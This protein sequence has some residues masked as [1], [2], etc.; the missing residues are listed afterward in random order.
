[1][2]AQLADESRLGLGDGVLIVAVTSLLAFSLLLQVSPQP[3]GLLGAALDT[4]QSLG[5]FALEALQALGAL[6]LVGLQALAELALESLKNL[7]G[8][9]P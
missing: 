2:H 1:M 5:S 6:A 7:P 3:E 8:I 4:T 9:L